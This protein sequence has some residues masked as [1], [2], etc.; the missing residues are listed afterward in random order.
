MVI[1]NMMT[2]E[3]LGASIL[4]DCSIAWIAFAIVLF[5]GLILKR[6]CEDGL[7]SGTNFNIFGALGFGLGAVVL[8]VTLFGSA[9]WGL[10]IGLAAMGAGGYLG[11]L[12]LG[13]DE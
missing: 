9:R 5:L 10:L 4:G 1:Y 7:L 11:G 3:N 2:C 13:G 6:Q 8:I 12:F